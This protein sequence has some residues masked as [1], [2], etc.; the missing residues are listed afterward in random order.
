MITREEIVKLANLSRLKLSE[1]EI[2]K[3]QGDMT[4]ILAYVDK[5]KSAK[6]VDHGPVMSVNKNV[7]REDKNPHE[8]GVYT[9]KLIK[10]APR[11]EEN[12]DGKYVKVKKILG[13]SQ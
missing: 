6:G 13:G 3:M 1:G 5:L 8:G 10:L 12:K 2:G 9:D 4:A 11:H 7:L